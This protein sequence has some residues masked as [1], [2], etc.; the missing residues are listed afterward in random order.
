MTP[1]VVADAGGEIIRHGVAPDPSV[2]A[3]AGWVVEGEGAPATHHVVGSSIVAYT[4]AQRAAKADR[5]PYAAGWSNTAFAWIDARPIEQARL[6]GWFAMKKARDA[7][8]FGGFTWSGSTFDSDEVS[9]ARMLGLFVSSKEAGFV[10]VGWRLADNSW[11]TLDAA[12][13]AGLWSALQAHV[14]GSF[15]R[16]AAKEAAI[17]GAVSVADIRAITWEG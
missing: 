2:H 11:R 3:W 8:I 13:A 7:A 14:Q 12:G 9:Q 4:D 10:P 5:P 16:F 1:F 15:E 17:G 6:D